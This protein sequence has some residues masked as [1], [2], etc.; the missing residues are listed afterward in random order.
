MEQNKKQENKHLV[1]CLTI[2]SK[3]VLYNHVGDTMIIYIDLLIL[4]NFLFDLLLLLTINIALKR[5]SKIYRLLLASLFGEITLIS[6]FIPISSGLF[7]ILKLIMGIIMVIIAFGY[8]NIKYT[9]YNGIYLY[10]TSVILG[11]FVYYLNIEFK[12]MNYIIILL[13]APIIL[14]IFIKSIKALKEIKNYYYKVKIVLNDN[15]ELSMAGFLDTGNKL[16]DP[17]TNK[18]IILLNKKKIKGN[19]NIRSPMYVPYN[20]LNHHGLIECIKPKYIIVNDKKLVNY[21]IGLSEE[22]FK[23]N[24][25]DCLLNY[26][27]LED[28]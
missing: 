20:S 9:I 4:V 15:Q 7:T 3:V 21:L 13:I 16:I 25:I 22:S 11:G 24:G 27:I 10:M 19:I 26:K 5:Y 8:K 28:I 6:L 17:I 12:N 1:F 14:Y 23:L 18:P 2:F